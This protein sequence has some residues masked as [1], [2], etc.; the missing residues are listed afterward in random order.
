MCQLEGLKRLNHEGAIRRALKE[1]PTT[2][3]EIYERILV[4][5]P[6]HDW[7][8]G[9]LA[10]A[11]LC[12]TSKIW[13]HGYTAEMVLVAIAYY[14]KD[15][16]PCYETS[17]LDLDA[18]QE[19][20]SCLISVSHQ[21]EADSF[22]GTGHSAIIA[23]Y[24][25][26]EFLTS[27]RILAGPAKYFHI[28]DPPD[29]VLLRSVMRYFNDIARKTPPPKQVLQS[30]SRGVSS[31]HRYCNEMGPIF[32]SYTQHM[33]SSDPHLLS[34]VI[35]I[36]ELSSPGY[37]HIM[38]VFRNYEKFNASVD[39][40]WADNAHSETPLATVVLNLIRIDFS[41]LAESI[42]EIQG[43]SPLIAEI[44]F[45]FRGDFE[46]SLFE[47]VVLLGNTQIVKSLLDAGAI[48]FDRT[49]ILYFV[50]FAAENWA[51]GPWSIRNECVPPCSLI[52]RF[53]RAN[54][55]P[56]PTGFRMTPLQVAVYKE[57]IES[58]RSLLEAGA[59]A[60][61]VGDPEGK[62][63]PML[64]LEDDRNASPLFICRNFIRRTRLKLKR[65]EMEDLL[66]A[67]SAEE[68]TVNKS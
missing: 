48:A 1:L 11:I 16:D 52:R 14:L 39:N 38:E 27:D 57:D 18:L 24:T 22:G 19:I 37:D 26:R 13:K 64:D 42:L 54:A 50:L 40:F 3:E 25:V 30:L 23:H 8:V 12:T 43:N 66:L 36:F 29:K 55:D 32:M 5:I 65:S 68:F 63:P 28:E 58:V 49:T 61:E 60:N 59:R 9:R 17:I 47:A 20:C 21:E 62:P 15:D 41:L 45:K 2:L 67:Y 56:S 53:L 10:L 33:I 35:Q 4:N 34:L 6:P 44:R 7:L 31:F 51:N 46:C